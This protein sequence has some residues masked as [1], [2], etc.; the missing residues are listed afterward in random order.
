MAAAARAAALIPEHGFVN[1]VFAYVHARAGRRADAERY[2]RLL[3]AERVPENY[4]VATAYAA[5]G[6]RERALAALER[7]MA[8]REGTIGDVGVDPAFASLRDEP[9]LQAILKKMKLR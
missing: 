3:E 9:R 1:G 8:A 2:I 4:L 5:L 7:A 6:E